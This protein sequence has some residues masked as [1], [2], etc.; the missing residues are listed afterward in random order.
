ML[1]IILDKYSTE[2]NYRKE[3]RGLGLG[4]LSSRNA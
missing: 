4:L 2:I 3:E 1:D